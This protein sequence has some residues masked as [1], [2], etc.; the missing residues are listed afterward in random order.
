M[1]DELTYYIKDEEI[2]LLIK[3]ILTKYGYDFSGYSHASFKR[4]LISIIFKLKI[5]YF[6]ELQYLIETNEI[7]FFTFLEEITVNVTEMFRDP[8]FFKVLRLEI[9]PELATF[10]NIRIWHAGCSTGEEVYSMAILL[11]EA[12]LLH[13]SLLYATDI[14]PT[15]LKSAA[16]GIF[17]LNSMKE[18]TQN[19]INSGL[20]YDFSGYYVV[21]YG[22]AYFDDE[23]KQ[24]M[25]FANHNLVSDQSFNEFNLI[26][27]RNVL[28]YF[29]NDF[30]NKAL[31]LFY[32]SLTQ[33]G[34]LALGNKESIHYS[35]IEEKL[36]IVNKYQRIWRKKI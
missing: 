34:F 4:R 14:N 8:D 30:Q 18:Y 11:K 24:R 6:A 13:R 26:L 22:K 31:N 29:N 2:D 3:T 17:P 21:K 28:I 36:Q 35:D 16:S 23:L 33:F 27:C 10:P 5:S 20:L 12:G 15:V 25:V 32:E 9:L 1:N 19:Y 7:F